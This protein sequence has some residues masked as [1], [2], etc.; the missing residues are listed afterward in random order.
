MSKKMLVVVDYQKDFVDGSL[1]FQGA[2]QLDEKI[3][4]KVQEYLKAGATV[5]VTRDTHTEDYLNTKEGQ[6]LPISHCVKGEDGW[7]IY[8][9]TGEI[10]NENAGKVYSI[11]KGAFGVSPEQ[12]IELKKQHQVTEILFVGLVS[13]ICVLS[14]VCCFQAAYPNAQITVE[15]GATA[16]FNSELNAKTMDVLKGIQVIVE[17]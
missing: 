9:R 2:A 3:T 17:D 11:D 16:S 12:M 14:N 13:N 5:V 1:G 7:Q 6:H 8:G 10:I 4:K 15:K